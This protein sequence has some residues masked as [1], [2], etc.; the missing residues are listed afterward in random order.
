M[1]APD[2]VERQAVCSAPIVFHRTLIGF[3][4]KILAILALVPPLFV[5]DEEHFLM[6]RAMFALLLIVL[7]VFVLSMRPFRSIAR[8]FT[9]KRE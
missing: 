4:I 3:L 6:I 7:V 1:V 5:S 2:L 9:K 8:Y